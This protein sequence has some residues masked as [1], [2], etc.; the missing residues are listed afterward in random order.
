M[1]FFV[2]FVSRPRFLLPSLC[3]VQYLDHSPPQCFN[4]LFQTWQDLQ[5]KAKTK[6]AS[7]NKSIQK[8]GG[9]PAPDPIDDFDEGV[10]ALINKNSVDGHDG[11]AESIVEFFIE[12]VKGKAGFSR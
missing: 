1:T 2:T 9:G 12:D 10:A 11:V 5:S 3:I 6:K 7:F 8:T 4:F